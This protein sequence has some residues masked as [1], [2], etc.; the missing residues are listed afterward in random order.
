MARVRFG[1]DGEKHISEVEEL[2]RKAAERRN[3][4]LLGW[5]AVKLF[6]GDKEYE[7]LLENKELR[8]RVMENEKDRLITILINPFISCGARLPV[9]ILIAGAVFARNVGTVVFSLYTAGILV[10]IT[11]GLI[12]RR[13][14]LK[15]PSTPFVMELP[16]YRLPALKG[17]LLHT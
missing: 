3:L 13:T 8:D 2:L 11:V 5:L 7:L 12:F 6:E 14:I 9:Y 16:P 1:A 17:I 15:G 4:P 10:A